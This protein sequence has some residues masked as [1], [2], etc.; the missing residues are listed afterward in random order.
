MLRVT[1]ILMKKQIINKG[2]LTVWPIKDLLLYDKKISPTTM[3]IKN[4]LFVF[5]RWEITWQIEKK[6]CWFDSF[7]MLIGERQK[8]RLKLIRKLHKLPIFLYWA[9]LKWEIPIVQ[10]GPF[11]STSRHASQRILFWPLEQKRKIFT[12]EYFKRY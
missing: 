11:L 7:T 12:V 10:N 9:G 5:E 4:D 3:R 8:R 1:T 6:I 2:A